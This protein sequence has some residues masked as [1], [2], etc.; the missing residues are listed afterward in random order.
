MPRKPAP[1]GSVFV[2]RDVFM[3]PHSFGQLA[4]LPEVITGLNRAQG[5]AALLQHVVANAVREARRDRGESLKELAERIDVPHSSY[6][7]FSRT[8]RGE[9]MMSFTDLCLWV[10]E[11]PRVRE[12]VAEFLAAGPPGS[13]AA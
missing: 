13:E 6:D 4:D 9:T 8:L 11:F 3:S 1:G 7:R 10:D 5:R 2:P 12:K